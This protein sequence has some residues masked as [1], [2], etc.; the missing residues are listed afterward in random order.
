[1]LHRND[2]PQLQKLDVC[3][4]LP[5]AANYGHYFSN[6]AMKTVPMAKVHPEP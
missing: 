6:T 2:H 4:L 5:V 3:F 1:M